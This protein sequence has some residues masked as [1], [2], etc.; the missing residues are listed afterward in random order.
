MPKDPEQKLR[1]VEGEMEQ[2][3]QRST[4]MQEDPSREHFDYS[5]P[6]DPQFLPVESFFYLDVADSDATLRETPMVVG[7]MFTSEEL[8]LGFAVVI[9]KDL[10][11]K[12]GEL[13]SHTDEGRALRLQY[14]DALKVLTLSAASEFCGQIVVPIDFAYTTLA[15]I[16]GETADEMEA[17]GEGD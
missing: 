14:A 15:Q 10:V 13:G 5:V 16:L 4:S 6:P 2:A 9:P 8:G 17:E 7:T 11:I 12:L 1:E 3:A